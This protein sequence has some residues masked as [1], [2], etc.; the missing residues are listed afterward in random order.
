MIDR[1]FS[2]RVLIEDY[3]RGAG[4][5]LSPFSFV[6]IFAWSD[7]FDFNV[8]VIDG[9]LCVFAS[10]AIG[11]FLYFP[12]ID[13]QGVVSCKCI[14][15]CFAV[16]DKVNSNRGVS[17]IENVPVSFLDVFQKD[18]FSIYMK[19]YEYCYY[20]QD[21]ISLTGNRYKS[22]RSDY[23]Y[24]VKNHSYHYCD[25]VPAMI[26]DC[27][28]LYQKW[29]ANRKKKYSDDIYQNMLEENLKLHHRL[30]SFYDELNLIGSVVF[31]D[32]VVRAYTLG[33]ELTE[34]VFCV[35]IEITDLLYKGLSTFIFRHFCAD[36]R[37]GKYRFINAMDDSGFV[38]LRQAKMSFAPSIM[39]PLYTV[40]RKDKE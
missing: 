36:D 14:N 26:D 35:F 30:L 2:S 37:L 20:K 29:Q 3:L 1:L 23:N 12:P 13:M 24:F 5:C 32:D 15:G 10:D 38:G 19:G 27:I 16:M 11:T 8:E 31:V 21:I 4:F 28:L 22:K 6:N 17:R 9:C 34:D 39:L 33:Y 7:F 18:D 40:S 25:F